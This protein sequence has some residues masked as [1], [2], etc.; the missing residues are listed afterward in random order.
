M[1]RTKKRR[2][3]VCGGKKYVWYVLAGDRDYFDRVLSNEWET[4]FLHIISED[5]K[6]ILTIPL[7][8]PKPYAVSKG[9]VFQGR[10]TSGCWERYLMPFELPEGI[11]P[12]FV[13]EVIE[14]AS[15]AES[16]AV[17]V[18]YDGRDIAF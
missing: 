4:P 11:T 10:Q 15:A 12:H 8:A 14:W 7:N 18:E 5:K 13:A 2:K 6:L 3:I 9:A 1:V 16:E 17:G